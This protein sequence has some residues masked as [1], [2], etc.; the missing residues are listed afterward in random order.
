MIV[1]LNGEFLPE[2]QASVSVLDRGFLFGDGIYEVIPVYG[3]HLFRLDQHLDRLDTSLAAIRLNNPLNH[4]QWSAL[5]NELVSKN[6]GG[7]LSVYLQ[8]T[9]GP[10]KRDHALPEI[11]KPTVFAM[12]N[13]VAPLSEEVR[14]KGVAAITLEDIRWKNCH[15]KAIALLP[16]VLL[17]QQAID[18]G[19]MESI[20]IREGLAT[21]GAAS[22]LFIVKD[23]KLIT[24]PKGPLLLPGITRDLVLELAH[25]NNI[26]CAEH[27]ISEQELHNADE[28]MLTS[29]TREI[30]PVTKLDD[31]PVGEGKPGALWKRIMELYQSYKRDFSE[32]K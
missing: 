8:I 2:E 30:L 32:Q 28:L 15:I 9:R 6:G 7:N 23:E 10:A 19:A 11:V 25:E 26:P 17:R 1:Y 18:S 31:H 16:N 4:G 3:G 29:S 13:L 20:L 5:L 14:E 22:N 21:E 27:V 12:C 24:P